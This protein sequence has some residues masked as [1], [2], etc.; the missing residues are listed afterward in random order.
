MYYCRNTREISQTN[1]HSISDG[2][3]EL[4]IN[5]FKTDKNEKIEFHHR[6]C[7]ARR[8]WVVLTTTKK[9][10]K[11]MANRHGCQTMVHFGMECLMTL[12]IWIPHLKMGLRSHSCIV[13]RDSRISNS[14]YCLFWNLCF[15]Q[16]R[17]GA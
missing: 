6:K 11:Q 8:C 4:T 14:S 15:G 3:M 7:Q 16:E 12:Y 1:V 17:K 2:H 9:K 10:M 13:R 5:S